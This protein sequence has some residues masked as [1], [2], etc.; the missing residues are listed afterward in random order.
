MP[1]LDSETNPPHSEPSF[2]ASSSSPLSI[3]PTTLLP[4]ST[5]ESHTDQ[6]PF[7]APPTHSLRDP[8]RSH[9]VPLAQRPHNTQFQ[10]PQQKDPLTDRRN[11]P[12]MI[13]NM[14]NQLPIK[15]SHYI[16]PIVSD[17]STTRNDRHLT[18][19]TIN[20]NTDRF[21]LR[22]TADDRTSTI[23]LQTTTKSW[24]PH[25]YAKPPKAPTPHSIGDILGVQKLNTPD[26]APATT[27]TV[28]RS[29]ITSSDRAN[30]TISQ[31]LNA[32]S[33]SLKSSSS[34]TQ[35]PTSDQLNNIDSRLVIGQFAGSESDLRFGSMSEECS[36]DDGIS[37]QPLNLSVERSERRVSPVRAALVLTS[38]QMQPRTSTKTSK[39]GKLFI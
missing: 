30:V 13:L 33:S 25:V 31:I 14:I 39:K 18:D 22:L 34:P 27:T 35:T 26:V 8:L 19:Y 9:S 5:W 10:A 32:K 24:H 1:E 36:E 21:G 37:D 11:S 15:Q 2:T 4:P 29:L 23:L 12:T 17:K 38:H 16:P 20:T 6:R 28:T 7:T 3:T